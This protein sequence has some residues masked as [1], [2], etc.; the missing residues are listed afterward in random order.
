MGQN[1]KDLSKAHSHA[2]TK[3]YSSRED[4][5][6]KAQIVMSE[7][8]VTRQFPLIPDRLDIHAQDSLSTSVCL[9]VKVLP[10]SG[11]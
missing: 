7:P 3:G 4:R 10:F 5:H 11:L 9:L 6:C 2:H 1:P 8:K